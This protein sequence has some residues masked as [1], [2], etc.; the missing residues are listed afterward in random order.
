MALDF[1]IQLL[2]PS[3]GALLLYSSLFLYE[4]EEGMVQNILEDWWVQLD[5]LRQSTGL[6]IFSLIKHLAGILSAALD[7]LFGDDLWSMKAAAISLY[8]LIGSVSLCILLVFLFGI[9]YSTLTGELEE[10]NGPEVLRVLALFFVPHL[11]LL[12]LLLRIIRSTARSERSEWLPKA[13]ILLIFFLFI[14]ASIYMIF[15]LENSGGI[16]TAPALL[17]AALFSISIFVGSY[18]SDVLLIILSR[19]AFRYIFNSKTLAS[20]LSAWF[21]CNA[22]AVVISLSP[23]A[24]FYARNELGDGAIATSL[25]VVISNVSAIIMASLLTMTGLAMFAHRLA[26]PL[27]QRPLYL[28]ARMQTLKRKKVTGGIGLAFLVPAL[29]AVAAAIPQVGR[30]LLP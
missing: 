1:L 23:L 29:P 10:I 8:L 16:V 19:V 15:S 3:L 4:D 18:M 13:L 11:A 14:N 28:L 2:L 27:I 12:Y 9:S 26:W 7:R 30:L 20:A 22:G 24:T 17:A 25:F 5:D 21:L 6:R